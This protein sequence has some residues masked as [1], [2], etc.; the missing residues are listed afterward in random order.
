MFICE[1][2]LVDA[3]D[4]SMFRQLV[5]TGGIP[6]WTVEER[7]IRI[8]LALDSQPDVVVVEREVRGT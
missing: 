7:R 5:N 3:D 4:V 6:D 2:Q 8:V 1:S